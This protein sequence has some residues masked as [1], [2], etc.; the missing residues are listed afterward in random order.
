MVNI[1]WVEPDAKPPAA[2]AEPAGAPVAE[3]PASD[4]SGATATAAPSPRLGRR[5][6]RSPR[7]MALSLAVLIIPIALV[8]TFYRVVLNGD[9]PITV[10]PGQSIQ[11]A[12]AAAVF[13]VLVPAGLSDDWH[14]ASS[15]WK[16][17]PEGATLRIGYVA[18]DDDS[19]LLVQSSIPPEQLLPV[20]IG[21][22]AEPRGT[23][24]DGERAWRAY[25]ARPGELALVLTEPGRTVVLVG[26]T[27]EENL[28]TLAA[29]LA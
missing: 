19:A 7:D 28:Q 3:P 21:R 10:D 5:E 14:V 9:A 24:R 26:T 8:L 13:P 16:P 20:E 12:R 25:D 4:T 22:T 18:P 29:S 1:G 27:D 15:A 23:F 11:Q 17:A 6:G 2:P